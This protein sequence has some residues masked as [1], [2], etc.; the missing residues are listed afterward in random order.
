MK[1][2]N[3]EIAVFDCDG[4]ILDSNN[5]KTDA[6]R[7]CLSDYNPEVVDRFISYHQANGGISRQV[8]LKAFL[9]E[10]VNQR[11]NLQQQTDDLLNRFAQ[12]VVAG[13]RQAPLVEGVL[14]VLERLNAQGTRCFVLSGGSQQE[15][16]DAFKV[17]GITH[18]FEAVLG[19]PT[20]KVDLAESLRSTTI[21]GKRTIYFGDAELDY[22]IAVMLNAQ[23][24]FIAK[25]SDWH[26]GAQKLKN[27]EGVWVCED[28]REFNSI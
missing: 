7:Q 18:L 19:N 6:F 5:L 28:F 21:L 24:V 1:L 9:E 23:F 22:Q 2:Q 15:I 13:L 3:F 17:K 26:E 25:H 10:F 8:K 11:E 16:L 20:P 27:Q 12:N 4:V 14:G